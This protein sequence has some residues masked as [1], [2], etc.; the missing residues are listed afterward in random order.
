VPPEIVAQIV[1]A[2]REDQSKADGKLTSERARLESRL[3]AI[4]NRMDAAYVDKL[5]GKISEDFWQRKNSEWQVDELQVK[6]AIDGLAGAEIGD[7]AM[8]AQRVLELANKAHLLYLTQSSTEKAKLLRMLCSNFSVNGASAMPA[9]R[10]PFDLIF[11]RAKLK[12]WSGR[13]D[14]NVFGAVAH[15]LNLWKSMVFQAHPCRILRA[16]S[17]CFGEA[18]SRCYLCVGS[19]HSHNEIHLVSYRGAN[20]PARWEINHSTN[21]NRPINWARSPFSS[22]QPTDRSRRRTIT[23]SKLRNPLPAPLWSARSFVPVKS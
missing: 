21:E 9:Y 3:T 20:A 4:R 5:D 6:M 10:Y 13:E 17:P 8:D 19:Q 18:L 15:W 23:H 14:L 22:Q 11:K 7:R 16:V 1:T 2:M 12:E